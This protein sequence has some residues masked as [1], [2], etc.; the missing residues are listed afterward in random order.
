MKPELN[1][2][3]ERAK[4]A[5]HQEPYIFPFASDDYINARKLQASAA[6]AEQQ[7][8]QAEGVKEMLHG[9]SLAEN[10]VKHAR[11]EATKNSEHTRADQQ[12]ER[13][14]AKECK[15]AYATRYKPTG[16]Q[17]ADQ[18]TYTSKNGLVAAAVDLKE[19]IGNARLGTILTITNLSEGSDHKTI[20]V[21]VR[22][23][24]G[25]GQLPTPEFD[26]GIKRGVDLTMKAAQLLGS[27]DMTKVE[28][29]WPAN[30][31]PTW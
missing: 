14:E 31:K 28:V 23:K 13:H 4:P 9:F 12:E 2:S 20:D 6:A 26:Q 15:I 5:D 25:F 1:F 8:P 24:G 11:T 7:R 16:N 27:G 3:P 17:T 30:A 19:P 22:D 21:R 29:C 10:T 18:S